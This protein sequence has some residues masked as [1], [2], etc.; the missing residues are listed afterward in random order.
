VRGFSVGKNTQ[1]FFGLSAHDQHI[2]SL[3]WKAETTILT[4]NQQIRFEVFT[5]GLEIFGF[6]IQISLK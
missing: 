1:F 2:K 4:E 6:D 5:A 3:L